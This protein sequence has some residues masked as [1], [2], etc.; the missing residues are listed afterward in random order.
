MQYVHVCPCAYFARPPPCPNL[1]MLQ[2]HAWMPGAATVLQRLETARQYRALAFASPRYDRESLM[3]A[4]P[5][6]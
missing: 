6:L 5:T 4:R 2:L 1:Q 3:T